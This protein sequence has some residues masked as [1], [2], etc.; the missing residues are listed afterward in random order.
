MTMRPL[1]LAV[2]G[3]ISARGGSTSAAFF[4]LVQAWLQAGN[5]VDFYSTGAWLD[6]KP[7]LGAPGFRYFPVKLPRWE[8]LR[9]APTGRWSTLAH[10]PI[11]F[12]LG[13]KAFALHEHAV[14][15]AILAE[16]RSRSYDALVVMNTL[17]RL[18]VW[19]A[20]P[21]ISFPQGPPAGESEFVRRE[22]RL[23]RD[24]IGW[25][26]LALVRA[27][28]ALRDPDVARGT[29]KSD[30]IVVSSE[31]SRELFR[32]AGIA[33]DRTA[34]LFPPV[35]LERFVA[36]PRPAD[37]R[38]FRFL[39]LGRIV[40]RK[41]FPLALEG[42]DRLH[43]RRPGAR[44]VVIGRPGYGS[45]PGN[46]R[47]PPCGPGVERR[48]PVSHD[49]VPALLARTDVIV[50]PSENENF[51]ATP[52]EG[53]ACGVPTVLGPTNGTADA[54]EDSAFKFDAYQPDDVAAAMERAMDAVL[55]DPV[56]ISRRARAIA[57]RTLAVDK[58]AARAL[59]LIVQTAKRKSG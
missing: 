23:V 24:D 9:R 10:K 44:L 3:P 59:D 33:D 26:G 40:P 11:E 2:Y 20:I 7:L 46:Y 42:F 37:P 50:Q 28:Y 36:A 38:D 43:R 16:H 31:W 8:W 29:S 53:L 55:A 54:L 41:R 19:G 48:P 56:G 58:T 30:L 39:W 52:A 57:E 6:L 1:R 45:L 15:E 34:I 13:Q 25:I 17:C 14:G 22:P 18:P 5:D 47:L 49:L 27:G 4:L 12:A 32:R 35:D 21:V 51:G